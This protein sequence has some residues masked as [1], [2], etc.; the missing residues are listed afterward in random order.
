M[1]LLFQNARIEMLFYRARVALALAAAGEVAYLGKAARD[2][3][4]LER[5]GA[6]WADALARLVRASISAARG[7][8]DQA[9]LDLEAAERALRDTAMAHYAAAAQYRRGAMLGGEQG[10]TLQLSA[11]AWFAGQ[12]VVNAPRLADLLTPG[13][14]STSKHE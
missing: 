14:W 10:R 7:P 3:A 1:M 13:A 12:N 6:S 5:E 11:M 8:G 2:A 9:L 4:R